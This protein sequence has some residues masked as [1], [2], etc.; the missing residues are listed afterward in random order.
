MTLPIFLD[1]ISRALM[2]SYSFRSSCGR[3]QEIQKRVAYGFIE[4]QYNA[5]LAM[6][7]TKIAKQDTT[8]RIAISC[9][10]KLDVYTVALQYILYLTSG[11]SLQSLVV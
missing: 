2:T 8:M 3:F 5:L 9:R 6:I 11:D 10:T 4:V 1:D 7:A